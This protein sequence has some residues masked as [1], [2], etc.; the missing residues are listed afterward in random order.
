MFSPLVGGAE[1]QAEKHAREL[2]ALGHDV[3]IVT[4]RHS[5]QWPLT[6]ILDGLPIVRI[7]GIY[8]RNGWMH[9]GRFGHPF[10]DL[11]M[12]MTLWKMRD[13]YDVIHVMQLSSVSAVAT[14]I[15]QLTKKPIMISIQSAGPDERQQQQMVQG[16]SLMADTLANTLPEGFLAVSA[17]DWIAGDIANLA[18]STFGGHILVHFL[19]KSDAFYQVLSTR[20]RSYLVANGFRS[21]QIVRIPNGID[22]EKF[23][24]APQRPDP[25]K[26]ER[27]ILCVARLEY[28][29]GVDV[30]L[31]AWGRMMNAPDEWRANLKPRLRL[32]GQGIFRPQMERIVA[33]LGI[34]DSVEFLGLRRDVV[35]LLQQAWGFVMPSRWEGMPNALLEAMACGLPC[36]A[37]CV[38][39]SEDIVIDGVNGL[40]VPPEQPADMA[41][42]LRTLIAADTT[43]TQHMAQEARATVLRDYQI[44]SIAQRCLRSYRQLRSYN[45]QVLPLA[46]EER[47]EL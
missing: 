33:E 30:L 17:K 39:G 35:D 31:H 18:R 45:Q 13:Q 21:E 16:V 20:C 2:Q 14:C 11:T 38:S 32:V 15:C 3:T 26:P 6:E 42:A 44:T 43:L 25:T 41:Q 34:Q 8:R 10:I 37:T 24:P 46:L 5:Q 47:G 27:D 22:T 36:V 7:K 9:I 29:K 28:P 40:L 23:R 4:L 19:R 12:F 1:V